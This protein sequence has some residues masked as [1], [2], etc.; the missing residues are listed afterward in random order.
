MRTRTKLM[1]HGVEAM[2]AKWLSQIH[3]GTELTLC[4]DKRYQFE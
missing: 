2:E 1:S 3:G 4:E